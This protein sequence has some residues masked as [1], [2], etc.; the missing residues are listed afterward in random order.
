MSLAIALSALRACTTTLPLPL[1]MAEEQAVEVS[2]AA[3]VAP[4][5][6]LNSIGL[7]KSI[8]PLSLRSGFGCGAWASGLDSGR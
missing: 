8:L 3:L 7:I 6:I 1:A 4:E 2:V 5:E